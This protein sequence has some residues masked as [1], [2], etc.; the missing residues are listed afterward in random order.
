MAHCSICSNPSARALIDGA[1]LGGDRP[2]DAHRFH[3]EALGLSLS[4]VY[5]H[6]RSHRPQHGLATLYV[7]DTPSGDLVAD[8]AAQ[9]RSHVAQRD[10][11]LARG[12]HTS[13]SREGHEAAQ[14]GLALLKTAFSDDDAAEGLRYHDH[15]VRSV[16]RA[17]RNRPEFAIEL[18][19]AAREFKDEEIA[20]GA[21]DLAK[22][23][24]RYH[25]HIRSTNQG[26]TAS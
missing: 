8:L 18:A 20:L 7:G 15:L 3:G 25:D 6:A 14:L 16:K 9:R 1:L 22:A 13:A 2:I 24:V 5:R 4:A 17:T 11:A 10:A 12:D 23:A 19:A 26:V 21:E